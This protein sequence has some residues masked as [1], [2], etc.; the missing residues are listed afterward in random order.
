MAETEQ[1]TLHSRIFVGVHFVLAGFD[2]LKKEQIR[3][4]LL[5]GGGVDVN[6]YGP[7]CTHL[8]VYRT[9]YDD[10]I[11]V[12]ARWDGKVLVTSLW[13]EHSFDVGMAVDHL[14]I[15]YRP[16]RG[17]DGIPGAKSLI[18]C[19]TGYQW[20]DRNDI[21]TM[22]GL[23][24]ANFTKPL[25][26]NKV[27]HLICYK[28]EGEKYE[29]AK[30]MK[31]KLVNHRWLEDCLMAWEILP[32]ACYDKSGYELEMMEAEAK[33]SEDERDDIAAN[34]GKERASF[35]SP[36]HSKSPDQ[37]LL[38]EEISR[39]ILEIHTPTGLSNFGNNKELLLCAPKESKSDLATAFEESHNRQF[40]THGPTM[41]RNEDGPHSMLRD[42]NILTSVSNSAKESASSCLSNSCVKGY[43]RKRPRK[44]SL[45]MASEQIESEGCPANEVSKHCDNFSMSSEK[46]QDG[47]DVGSAKIPTTKLACLK[48]GQSGVLP[49]KRRVDMLYNGSPKPNHNPE[50]MLDSDLGVKSYS[51]KKSGKIGLNMALEKIE[52]AG[53]PPTNVVSQHCGNLN[54]SSEKEQDG[55]EVGPTE[56]P[57]SKM[58]C[59]EKGQSGI[60]PA[61]SRMD[62]LF[63]GS[64]KT[65]HSPENVLDGDLVEDRGEELGRHLSLQNNI[66]FGNGAGLDPLKSC[67]ASFSNSIKHGNQR[68]CDEDALQA[69]N[70]AVVGLKRTAFSSNVDPVNFHSCETEHSTGEQNCPRSE[71]QAVKNPSPGNEREYIE[72]S[73]QLAELDDVVGDARSGS[74]P[75]KIK[76]L[77]KKTLGSGLSLCEREARNQKGTAFHNKTVSANDSAPSV[78]WGRK[79]RDHQE[80]LSIAKVE[81]PPADSA[82]S[83]K[84]TEKRKYFDSGK[85]DVKTAESIGDN[86]ETPENKEYDELNVLAG[87]LTGELQSLV[88][89]AEKLVVNM[90]W[91]DV[92]DCAVRHDGDNKNFETQKTLS[93]K[94]T[95]SNKSTSAENDVDVKVTKGPK[96]LMKR[97][98]TNNLAAKRAVISRRVAKRKKSENNKKQNV[99]IDNGKCLPVTGEQT[100]TAPDHELNSMDMDKENSPL[101][102]GQST[103]HNDRGAG[104]SSPKCDN[105]RP[106]KAGVANSRSLQVTK[107]GT[108]PRWF[109]LSGH[110]L[111]RKEFEKVIKRLKGNVCRDSHQWSYQATHFIVPDPVRRT[112][113][114][115]AAAASGRW[116]LKSDYLTASNE[117]GRLLDEK[118]YEW[119]KK[120]LTEDLATDLE[121]PRKWRLLRERTG[122]GAFYGMKIIIYGDCIVPPLDTLK[123]AVKAGDGTILATSPPYTRF[124]NSGVDFAVVDETMPL[125]D[126]WVQEFLRC[127][128][129][130][131]LPDYLV[132]YVCKPGYPRDNYVQY[133]TH[134]WVERSLKKLADCLEEL[135]A[136]MVPPDDTSKMEC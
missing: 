2:S 72:K 7:D 87:K 25:I 28:F 79:D 82:E 125:Y 91:T 110:R 71:L 129:P 19:L 36:Q 76:S 81:V 41:N 122:H 5:E 98:K 114:L 63:N 14:S 12:A 84:E 10:P 23:M 95:R 64:P 127:E 37:F 105:K 57:T 32:E 132:A 92:K 47:T 88:K 78:S 35:T 126:M 34:M 58:P 44:I 11:C 38:K 102:G 80:V 56:I 48:K 51:R 30:K 119:Y 42:G 107:V 17:L 27:T 26:G 9:V 124:L 8:I 45:A 86:T 112:E 136:D 120:G 60:L 94:N 90:D 104:R 52:S 29:L 115:F 83:S 16:M 93:G 133:N 54:I 75:L 118:K 62:M 73:I 33:D 113:K 66:Q 18:L 89:P 108:E 49:E 4:K 128:I 20:Q 6:E 103:N 101:M 67:D 43:S 123:R 55:T 40:E 1:V 135:V 106:L 130:C 13:V 109:I 15:M 68:E 31:I 70:C 131:I 53:C 99:E 24:G 77:S 97:G 134:T 74:K 39:N 85:K 46:E 21:M 100:G 121:A 116:I 22:V 65:N 111:Q 59:L 69:A 117:A 61:K 96:Y 50:S 3:S